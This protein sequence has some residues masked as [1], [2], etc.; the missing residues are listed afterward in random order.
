MQG[1]EE[2]E[3]SFCRTG[4]KLSGLDSETA[5]TGQLRRSC[6]RLSGPCIKSP[7]SAIK[8][9]LQRYGSRLIQR[10]AKRHRECHLSRKMAGP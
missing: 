2:K 9:D 8:A 3:T 7:T 5:N 4:R 6:Y 1:G 10:D